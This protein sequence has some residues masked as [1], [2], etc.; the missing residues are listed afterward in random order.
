MR[1]TGRKA[2]RP[3]DVRIAD[4][5][6]LAGGLAPQRICASLVWPAHRVIAPCSARLVRV[7]ILRLTR[8][9]A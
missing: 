9:L 8:P 5:N 7:E 6:N 3:H 1:A 2:A 4:I